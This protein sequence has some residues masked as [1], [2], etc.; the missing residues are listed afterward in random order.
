MNHVV[1]DQVSFAERRVQM[2]EQQ[3]RARGVRD[4]AVLQ[5]FNTVPRE[6]F[7]PRRLRA[8]AYDD[9]PLPIPD[10][11]TISQPYVVAH[12]ISLL[13]LQP[14]DRVLEIGTGS[15][16]AAAV[17]SQ[18]VAEVH[19]VERHRNLVNY[20]RERLA[21]LGYA[22][23]F[24]HHGDGSLGWPEQAPYKGII[25]AAGGP[26]VPPALQEQLA[27]NGRLVIPIG[28]NRRQQWLVLVQR[29]GENSYQQQHLSAVA[30]VPLIG[31]QG[32]ED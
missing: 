28:P 1:K 27:I 26:D 11:Q 7:V 3:L 24:V 20:A 9:S 12:M 13:N 10:G 31:A 2:V 22:N 30:F 5:A 29:T 23:V 15:G 8:Y 6:L 17:L 14:G 32:W 21:R 19:T 18:I 25:V 4:T 16:Y